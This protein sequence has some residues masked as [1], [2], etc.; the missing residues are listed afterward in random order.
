M[1]CFWGQYGPLK[2][3]YMIYS[4]MKDLCPCDC[5]RWLYVI[6]SS[7][8]PSGVVDKLMCHI[9]IGRATRYIH[10]T[11]G[12]HV[13]LPSQASIQALR[14]STLR[15]KS[16]G[17]LHSLP[18]PLARALTLCKNRTT[19]FMVEHLDQ[20]FWVLFIFSTCTYGTRKNYQQRIMT[21]WIMTRWFSLCWNFIF[22]G[23][24]CLEETNPW[25]IMSFSRNFQDVDPHLNNPWL[26]FPKLSAYVYGRF[27]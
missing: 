15:T 18:L 21:R 4:W 14:S 20:K 26:V 11:S 10:G 24:A 6:G 1:T 19:D 16:N 8:C 13:C 22:F 2:R 17:R 25:K 12:A 7:L 9:I 3:S 27:V 23:I 5:G